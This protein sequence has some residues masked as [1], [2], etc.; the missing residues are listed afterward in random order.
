MVVRPFKSNYQYVDLLLLNKG[1]YGDCFV[2]K[3]T[4]IVTYASFNMYD[5]IARVYNANIT[6]SINYLSTIARFTTNDNNKPLG[7]RVAYLCLAKGIREIIKSLAPM[8]EAKMLHQITIFDATLGC[9]FGK[10]MHIDKFNLKNVTIKYQTASPYD[11]KTK[12]INKVAYDENGTP[13]I[14]E[15]EKAQ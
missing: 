7:M 13:T 12:C 1:Q 14:M 2:T 10:L 3:S 8:S 5:P 9:R 6:I 15:E 11:L 4:D